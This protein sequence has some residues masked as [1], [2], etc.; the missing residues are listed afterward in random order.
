MKTK[1]TKSPFR[2]SIPWTT[3]RHRRRRNDP[4]RGGRFRV[5]RG[6][7]MRRCMIHIVGPRVMLRVRFIRRGCRMR[8]MWRPFLARRGIGRV[9]W[10]DLIRDIV[11][12]LLVM[13]GISRRRRWEPELGLPQREL[14]CWQRGRILT[15]LRGRRL[16]TKNMVRERE[17]LR[18]MRP[19]HITLERL[20]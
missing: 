11:L 10:R 5:R 6:W 20:R 19:L 14:L 12:G 18:H 1:R 3:L 8:G 15:K 13:I 16:K 2:K 4:S 7:M 17:L 9:S